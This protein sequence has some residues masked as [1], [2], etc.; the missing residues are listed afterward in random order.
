MIQIKDKKNCCGCEVCC[1]ICPT[2]AI[3]MCRDE[4]GFL[5]PTIDNNKCIDCKQCEKVCPICHEK[6]EDEDT[7]GYIV[8]NKNE[9]VLMNSTSGGLFTV[10]AEYVLKNNGIVYGA[11]YDSNMKVVYKRAIK[12][13]QIDEMRGSKFVQSLIGDTYKNVKEDLKKNRLVLFTGTPCQIYALKNYLCKEYP[14]LLCIDFVCR[15]VPS[16]GLWEK[17]IQYMQDKY[18]AKIVDVKF[19]NKTYGYHTSTMKISFANNKIY[20][21]S[22]RVDPYMK[23]FVKEISSRPSCSSCKFKGVERIS[24][25]TMFDCYNYSKI[26][27]KNDDD[28][29]YSSIL[30]HTDL[31]K[32]IFEEIK[33]KLVWSKQDIKSLIDNNGIMVMNSAKPHMRRNEFFTLLNNMSL[34]EALNKIE[35][36]KKIDFFIEN[37]KGTLYRLG[38]MELIKKIF[39]PEKVQVVKKEDI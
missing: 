11:G 3:Q 2:D 38:V 35:P 6:K 28:K 29:G 17:Y 14:N 20:Y 24:D 18:H 36:I 15:G 10:V 32:A 7:V 23:A 1:N 19:K 12:E 33:D 21:G 34:D 26:T 31:G 37:I 4:E 25:I 16:P 27:Q 13:S 30:V 9:K 5:Y 8:R 22:G 39:K